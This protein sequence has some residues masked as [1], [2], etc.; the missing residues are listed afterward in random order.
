MITIVGAGIE[1]DDLTIK[2]KKA[3]KNA[4]YVFSRDKRKYASECACVLFSNVATFDEYDEV[5][6]NHLLEKEKE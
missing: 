5:I 3:I 1:K 2:G 6:A 4:S